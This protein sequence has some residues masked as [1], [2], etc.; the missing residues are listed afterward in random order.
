MKYYG[1]I[2]AFIAA[3]ALCTWLFNHVH[4]WVGILSLLVLGGIIIKKTTNKLDNK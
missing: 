2:I 4:A 3:I 1:Y